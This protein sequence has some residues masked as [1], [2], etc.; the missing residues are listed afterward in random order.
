MTETCKTLSDVL[1]LPVLFLGRLLCLLLYGEKTAEIGAG[2]ARVSLFVAKT[3][4]AR[5]WVVS[6]HGRVAG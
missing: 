5:K 1:D 6:T 3:E 2:L 4:H